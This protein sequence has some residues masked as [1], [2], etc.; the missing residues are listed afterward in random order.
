M[1]NQA[2]LSVWCKNFP[3][4]SILERFGNFLA[5]VPFSETKPGF[6]HL[7]I[8][9]VDAVESPVL[10]Q[11]LRGLPLDAASIVEIAQDHLNTDCSYEVRAYCDLWVYEDEAGQWKLEPQA[12]EI[13]CYGEDFDDGFWRENGHLQ[14]NFGF[15][16]FF[17]GHAGML[18]FRPGPKVAPQSPEE[19]RFL[20][21]MSRPENLSAYHEKTRDNI[22]K[23]LEWERR[24]EKALPV[25]QIPLWS[26]GEEN[27]EARL[28]EIL[29][30]R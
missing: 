22:R 26:E 28:E 11:D 6:R 2:Y 18:G 5:S 16:H 14:V 30:A 9:A 25:A 24:I 4:D 15:E 7:V 17:T 12:L 23:L 21:A 13:S 19:A 20:A 10:E 29:A 1:A 27:F 3:E 8:R